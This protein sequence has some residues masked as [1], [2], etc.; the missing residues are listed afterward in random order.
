MMKNIK[1]YL[2]ICCFTGLLSAQETL[3]KKEA[4][5]ITLENNYGILLANNNNEVAANN[6]SVYNT[7]Y[8]PTVTGNG[9][10]TYT[11]NNSDFTRQNGEKLKVNNAD[12]QN[13][14]ASIGLNYVLFDGFGRSYNFKKLQQAQHLSKLETKAVIEQTIIQL[15]NNYYFV[16][17]H[18]QHKKLSE[19][20]LEIS[21]SRLTRAQYMYEYGQTTKLE[22][23]NAEVDVNN[24]RIKLINITQLLE[25]SKRE[26]NLIL[27]RGVA[28]EFNV[29]NTVNFDLAFNIETLLKDAKQQNIA[30]QQLNKSIDI[31]GL[32]LKINSANYLPSLNFN[33]GYR[34]SKSINDA[35]SIFAKQHLNGLSAGLNL[36]WNIFDGGRTKTRVANSKIAV[37]NL[38]IQESLLKDELELY[39]RNAFTLYNND[40][41]IIA[42]EK[43][44][45]ETNQRNFDR[46]EERY[47]LGQVTS[48]EF[49]Q[50]QINL[51]NAQTNLNKA[52][53]AAKTASLTL[54]QLSGRLL[55]Q[56][57]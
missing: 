40:L 54:L 7:G 12:S 48:I 10:A 31:A 47:K 33:G 52:T 29:E 11:N 3:T 45:V 30:M 21:K 50:A 27:G 28:T 9:N 18:E 25:N 20:S 23:L 49:R 16:A 1:T 56:Q 36:S 53:Y 34:W 37:D 19:T 14:G 17:E 26:I 44:N 43:K 24:D 5:A 42:S 46:T 6:T 55:D 4:V 41:I 8:L 15:F 22:I 57:F 39:V 35:T 32:D 38:K 13:Y 2:F 51:L